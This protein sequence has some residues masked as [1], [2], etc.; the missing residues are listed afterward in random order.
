MK[1][2]LDNI[3]IIGLLTFMFLGY[4][5]QSQES[6]EVVEKQ[7]S[8]FKSDYRFSEVEV[9]IKGL[10]DQ[11]QNNDQA[12]N[13]I[14]DWSHFIMDFGKADSLYAD[15]LLRDPGNVDA[16]NG[17]AMIALDNEQVEKSI[18][19]IMKAI[20]IDSTNSNSWVNYAKVLLEIRD[21]E[22]VIKALDKAIEY[23]SLN[24]DAY[25]SKG[26]YYAALRYN[27]AEG[28]IFFNKAIEINPLTRKAHHYLGRGYS[29]A[30]YSDDKPLTNK[31]LL[32]VDSLLSINQ[33]ESAH[34]LI[35]TEYSENSNDIHALKLMVACEFHLSN[36]RMTIDYA[37]KILELKPNYGLAHYF[38]A[39]SLNQLKYKHNILMQQFKSDYEKRQVPP[40]VPFL[41][42]VFINYHQ[43]E[44]DLQKII[45][46]N[47]FQFGGFMEALAI[48]DATVYFM[49]FHHLMFECPHLAD[50]KGTRA[51]DFRLADDIKGQGGYHMNSN[52]LQQSKEAFGMFNVAFHEFAHL[53]QWLFTYE[54]NAELMRLYTK[55]RTEKRTLDWYADMNVQEYFAQGVEAYLSERKLPGQSNTTNNTKQELLKKDIELFKFIESLVNQESY[56][57]HIV[58]GLIVKSWYADSNED[59]FRLLK[60]A[61]EKYPNNP[62]LL[63]ELGNL[64][65][66]QIDFQNAEKLHRQVIQLY[67][68]NLQAKLELSYD[69]FLEG[70][71]KEMSIEMLETLKNDPKFDAK[72]Y[73][74]LGFYYIGTA[75][76]KKAVKNLEIAKKLEPFPDPY[77]M[78]LP[79]VFFLLAKA[80]L[81][82]K[83]FQ[84]AEE[85]LLKS[86]DIN[87][88]KAETYAELAYANLKQ[89]KPQQAAKYLNT[90][91]QLNPT[92]T[93]VIEV[94]K[95]LINN[96]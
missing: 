24:A 33:F 75:D 68:N 96:E 18:E 6:I 89:N 58:Q 51:V 26:F 30:N 13:L 14:A 40:A 3:R 19:L 82:I 95:S 50:K 11:F 72:M 92:N 70:R 93:R 79:D 77:E 87:R 90:A 22:G 76:Y 36:Y 39:E 27:I 94:K 1:E 32:K 56:R 5:V 41:E 49:D 7:I 42:D 80:Q 35:T 52:K 38:I 64:H 17:R 71:N 73:R 57:K 74:F 61:L 48:S 78:S 69:I 43:C 67:P 46:I 2:K 81:E 15:V 65:R 20:K 86:L 88:S 16:L 85:N 91:K 55:A 83:D 53:I 59:V 60:N 62:V 63:M 10:S 54:Q 31:I 45:K 25:A 44:S 37:F 28:G 9:K 34:T 84:A 4:S 8:E 21:S 29:P 47:T 23:D 66:N 12:Q